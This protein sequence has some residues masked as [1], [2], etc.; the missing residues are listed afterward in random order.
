MVGHK[1]GQA[2]GPDNRAVSGQQQ[3][4]PATDLRITSEL[5]LLGTEDSMANG[6]RSG[7]Q[8][9]HSREAMHVRYLGHLARLGEC[10]LRLTLF[11]SA[12]EKSH[13]ME[14]FVIDRKDMIL[15]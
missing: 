9:G 5:V 3:E 11:Y 1:D 2:G 8:E 4:P 10:G 15:I 14:K 6:Q 13:A 12:Y 7:C